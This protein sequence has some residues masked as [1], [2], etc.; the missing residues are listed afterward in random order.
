[1]RS[2]ER[3]HNRKNVVDKNSRISKSNLHS[4]QSV[5]RKILIRESFR[6]CLRS[7]SMDKIHKLIIKLNLS[8]STKTDQTKKF[9]TFDLFDEHV[10]DLLEDDR[11]RTTE[12]YQRITSK[13]LGE[14]KIPISTIYTNHRV[15][16]A[17]E[18]L[19]LG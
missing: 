14:F 1:M 7:M 18:G 15:C 13:W 19:I 12:L 5:F 9:L 4:F 10:E 3:R 6:I 17:S 11:A 2:F 16:I 8:C